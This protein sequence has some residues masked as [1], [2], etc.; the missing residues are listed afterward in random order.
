LCK[1]NFTPQGSDL[2]KRWFPDG[3]WCQNCWVRANIPARP[4]AD[5]A[6]TAEKRR[7]PEVK[8]LG[9]RCCYGNASNR[10]P[11]TDVPDDCK[12]LQLWLPDHDLAQRH[13][14]GAQSNGYLIQRV[15]ATRN[16][17]RIPE[18]HGITGNVSEAM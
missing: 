2:S 6:E 5:G 8:P 12:L 18:N 4:E 16:A 14:I 3:G 10:W 17:T 7:A 13:P 15:L 9:Q 1:E 11:K